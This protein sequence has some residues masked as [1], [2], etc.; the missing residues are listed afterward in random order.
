MLI[1]LNKSQSPSLSS[2][3]SLSSLKDELCVLFKLL[4]VFDTCRAPAEV[5]ELLASV[6]ALFNEVLAPLVDG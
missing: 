1:F 2:S 3:S 4:G 5:L 6:F